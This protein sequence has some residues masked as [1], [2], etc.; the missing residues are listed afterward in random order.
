MQKTM[1]YSPSGTLKVKLEEKLPRAADVH[2]IRLIGS[3]LIP[4]SSQFP[5]RGLV[6]FCDALN[7]CR[8]PCASSNGDLEKIIGTSKKPQDEPDL[9]DELFILPLTETVKEPPPYS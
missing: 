2:G 3:T 6:V 4:L 9:P 1:S 5:S 7:K 8:F